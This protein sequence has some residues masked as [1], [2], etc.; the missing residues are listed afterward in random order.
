MLMFSFVLCCICLLTFSHD[1]VQILAFPEIIAGG[2]Q[3]CGTLNYKTG[4]LE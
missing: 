1:A 3:K 2:T 4:E